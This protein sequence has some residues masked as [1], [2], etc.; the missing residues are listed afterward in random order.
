MSF[1]RPFK[2]GASYSK[3][4]PIYRHNCHWCG[5]PFTGSMDKTYCSDAC[6]LNAWRERKKGGASK[7]PEIALPIAW[8]SV[9]FHVLHRDGFKCRYCGRGAKENVVLHVD[10][11]DPKSN[12]GGNSIDNLITACQE[13]NLGKG[14]RIFQTRPE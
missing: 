1:G 11:F 5:T 3:T 9:R 7:R 14:S 13:C 6:R 12:G 8:G 2:N 4:T 10:H